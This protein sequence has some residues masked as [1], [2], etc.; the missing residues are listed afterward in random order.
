VLPAVGCYR[1][2]GIH[3]FASRSFDG[4]LISRAMDRL[5]FGETARGSSSRGGAS[6]LL[7]LLRFL[8]KGEHVAVTVDGPRG[9]RRRAQEGVLKLAELSGRAVVPF[10]IAASPGPR[11]RSWD[12]MLLPLPFQELRVRFG[13]PLRVARGASLDAELRQLQE[14]L[15]R[16]TQEL[17]NHVQPD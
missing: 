13:A 9:P 17:E 8:E 6:G 15:D 1:D 5:G 4:E 12:R 14:G 11:L 2:L 3:P 16:L 7:E 10:G